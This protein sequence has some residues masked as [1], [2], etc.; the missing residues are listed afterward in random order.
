M[1]AEVKSSLALLETDARHI[2]KCFPA[3][4]CSW[5]LLLAAQPLDIL[6]FSLCDSPRAITHCTH[7]C[8]LIP[9]HQQL[10]Y[11]VLIS[12]VAAPAHLLAH[13]HFSKN[14][15]LILTLVRV[16]NL[17]PSW[18]HLY[19]RSLTNTPH[20]T[21]THCAYIRPHELLMVPHSS[22]KP[23][24]LPPPHQQHVF[25]CV[26]TCVLMNMLRHRLTPDIFLN[27]PSP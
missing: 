21:C 15:T 20:L 2:I 12:H 11:K 23:L 26:H 8:I 14:H 27:H 3:Q 10:H 4:A 24:S 22:Q 5:S 13:S 16:F 18:S 19:M 17:A 25:V 1:A 7:M 9:K 6:R